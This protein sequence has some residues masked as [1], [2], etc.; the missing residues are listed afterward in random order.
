V[1]ALAEAVVAHRVTV[2]QPFRKP[3]H[4]TAWEYV[5]YGPGGKRGEHATETAPRGKGWD[6]SEYAYVKDVITDVDPATPFL[7]TTTFV[8][9]KELLE[10]LS[11]I[12]VVVTEKQ[13]E[14]PT[15]AEEAMFARWATAY[16]VEKLAYWGGKEDF[17][18]SLP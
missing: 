7:K 14:D 5:W 1:D 2:H 10:A 13:I 4:E 3:D 16:G 18:E 8:D 9:M 12:H 15:E 11:A 6:V 17:V